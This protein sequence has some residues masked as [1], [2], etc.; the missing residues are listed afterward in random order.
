MIHAEPPKAAT[1][2]CADRAYAFI[3]GQI[4]DGE[5]GAGMLLNPAEIAEKLVFSVIPVRE[6]MIRLKAR[7][8]LTQSGR[9][10][11]C[12]ATIEP[13]EATIIYKALAAIYTSAIERY[14]D[15]RRMTLG[16]IDINALQGEDGSF[17][18]RAYIALSHEVSRALLTKNEYEVTLVLLDR[19]CV[20]NACLLRH[21]DV[22]QKGCTDLVKVCEL[23]RSYSL[24]AV[25]YY[26]K[27]IAY[28]VNI[29]ATEIA[30]KWVS[31]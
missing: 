1:E 31:W 21:S 16:A 9:S 5:Y 3:R 25:D 29:I 14:I 18:K 20:I 27:M 28:I 6:A 26:K 24:E 23:T 10:G 13:A 22:L 7:G 4:L 2:T 17:D 12:I 15:T 30:P 8:L 11:Y 19:L